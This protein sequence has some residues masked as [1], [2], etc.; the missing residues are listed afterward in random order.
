MSVRKIPCIY[1]HDITKYNR[2]DGRCGRCHTLRNK[3]YR[4]TTGLAKHL[5]YE[6]RRRA[7]PERIYYRVKWFIKDRIKSKMQKVAE[8]ERELTI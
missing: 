6:S 2:S 4:Q 3:K 8:L 1:G 5:D 7:K